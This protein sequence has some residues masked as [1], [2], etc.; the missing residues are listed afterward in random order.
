VPNA[1]NTAVNDINNR[2]VIVGPFD[3]Q[4]G[5]HGYML[6]DGVFTSIDFPG[7]DATGAVGINDSGQIVGRFIKNGVDHGYLLSNGSF[8][9]IDFPVQLQRSAMA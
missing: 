9:Q 7:A 8:S 2:G 4:N 5:T 3:D 6:A 1:I